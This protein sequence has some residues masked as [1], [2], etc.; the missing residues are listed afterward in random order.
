MI[1]RAATADALVLVPRGEGELAAGTAGLRTSACRRRPS[2]RSA[3][4][5]TRAEHDRAD[6][7]AERPARPALAARRDTARSG[8]RRPPRAGHAAAAPAS[9]IANRRRLHVADA[10]QLEQVP[11]RVEPEAVAPARARRRRS[12]GPTGPATNSASRTGAR[13]IRICGSQSQM[14]SAG[15]TKSSA[16]GFVRDD[17][18]RDDE[19][20]RAARRCSRRAPPRRSTGRRDGEALAGERSSR[21]PSDDARAPS[22]ASTG[23]SPATAVA[24]F[25]GRG[26]PGGQAPSRRKHVKTSTDEEPEGKPAA[27]RPRAP[28]ASAIRCR[29]QSA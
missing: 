22:S 3:R 7:L 11:G 17:E 20:A 23:Q 14:C 9:A 15:S 12:P 18:Q 28:A 10:D 5:G 16:N 13:A 2:A 6:E 21:A 25:G 8:R 29:R 24:G 19:R 27:E 1:A 4:R 26:G